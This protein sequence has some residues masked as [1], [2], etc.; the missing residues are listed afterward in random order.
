MRHVVITGV[1]L[2]TPLGGTFSDFS[3][4]LCSGASAV[5]PLE[6]RFA[7]TI[8]AA[9]VEEDVDQHFS[10]SLLATT[11]RVRSEEHTSELQSH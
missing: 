3:S 8:G 2:C 10:K 4:A 6:T 5:R 7:G 1:G 11:D 9:L